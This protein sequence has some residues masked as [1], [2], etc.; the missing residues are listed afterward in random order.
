MQNLASKKYNNNWENKH[1]LKF[2]PIKNY[3]NPA[4]P[5]KYIPIHIQQDWKNI[6]NIPVEWKNTKV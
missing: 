1:N 6:Y 3:P 4:A 5:T 2:A